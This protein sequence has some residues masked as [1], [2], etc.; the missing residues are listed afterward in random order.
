M[1][2]R[3]NTFRIDYANFPRKPSY[4]ELHAFVSTD[5]GL[6]KDQVIRIQPSRSLQCVFVKVA[7]LSLAQKIVDEHDNKHETEIDGKSYKIRIKLEDGAVEVKLYDL[8]EDVDDE[9]IKDYLRAYGDVLAIREILWDEKFT[10]GGIPTGVREVKMSV[11]VFLYSH[12]SLLSMV[13]SRPYHITD[14]SK[15]VDTAVSSYT[16]AYLVYRTKNCWSKNLIRTNLT[17]K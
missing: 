9:K 8:S 3:E 2:R 4:E 13:K 17:R 16:M 5:L 10:F 1:R 15:H 14:N 7:E 6:Q 11:K 12:R